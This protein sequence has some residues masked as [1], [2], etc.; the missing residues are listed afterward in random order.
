VK[1][2]G[3]RRKSS[4]GARWFRVQLLGCDFGARNLELD[5]NF[6]STD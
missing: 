1:N 6:K 4:G 5:L 2:K 3:Y